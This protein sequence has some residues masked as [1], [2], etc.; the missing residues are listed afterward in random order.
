MTA[1]LSETDDWLPDVLR[2]QPVG[3]DEAG[4]KCP[5][6]SG[7]AHWLLRVPKGACSHATAMGRNNRRCALLAE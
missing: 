5:R 3:A 7:N 6:L 4:V 2:K 1:L